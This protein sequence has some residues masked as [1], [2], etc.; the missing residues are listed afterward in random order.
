MTKQSDVDLVQDDEFVDLG[1]VSLETEG[2]V[3]GP[4]EN[5]PQIAS[6]G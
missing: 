6:L 5:A 2:E 3:G 4:S 1:E